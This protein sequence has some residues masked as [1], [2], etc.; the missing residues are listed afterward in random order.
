MYHKVCQFPTG[1]TAKGYYETVSLTDVNIP[2]SHQTHYLRYV[3]FCIRKMERGKLTTGTSYWNIYRN[4]CG[5]Q[6]RLPQWCMLVGC[7][8]QEQLPKRSYAQ[9]IA[10]WNPRSNRNK[11]KNTFR[12]VQTR[13]NGRFWEFWQSLCLVW[14]PNLIPARGTKRCHL[15][16]TLFQS[17][18]FDII[19][20]DQA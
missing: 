6:D 5:R 11:K 18:K 10:R 14:A 9:N 7:H 16:T 4:A 1:Q 8:S 12:Y 19:L 2:R 20:H 15:S 3:S 17:V 13:L